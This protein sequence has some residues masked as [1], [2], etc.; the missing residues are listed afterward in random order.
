MLTH[1][2][3]RICSKT[4]KMRLQNV[5]ITAISFLGDFGLCKYTDNNCYNGKPIKTFNGKQLS[6]DYIYIRFVSLLGILT[7]TR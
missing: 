5:E 3:Y 4:L 2:D 7:L 6:S 1:K